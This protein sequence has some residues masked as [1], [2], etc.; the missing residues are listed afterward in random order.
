MAADGKMGVAL[1]GA[2]LVGPMHARAIRAIPEAR[3]AVVC[4]RDRAKARAFAREFETDW[5]TD[6]RRAIDRPDVELVDI[7]TPPGTH[8]EIAAY[9]AERKK[10]VLVEKPI[11]KTVARGEALIEACRTRGVKLGVIYQGRFKDG[12]LRLKKAADEGRLGRIFL[13]DGYVKWYRPPSYY[14]NDAWRGTWAVEGGGAM[15]TQAI[16]VI[17][18]LLWIAGPV[19]SVYAHCATALHDIETEDLCVAV[20]QY[21]SGALGVLEGSTA[22]KPG[23]P[24]RVEVHGER[25]TV[26]VEAGA[27][28]LWEVDGMDGEA[29]LREAGASHGSGASDPMAFTFAWHQGQIRDMIAA[30]REDREPVVTG[31]AALKSLAVVEAVHESARTGLP[32]ALRPL[33]SAS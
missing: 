16:H 24:D 32:V 14:A 1:I 20:L 6:F 22:L 4:R 8:L 2:G 25:G 5:E 3:L 10:H 18:I 28:K 31:L 9:A 13:A 12:C 7:S 21:Q 33:S 17:D 11:D 27:V 26:I 19:K 29:I 15:I 30:I 23:L